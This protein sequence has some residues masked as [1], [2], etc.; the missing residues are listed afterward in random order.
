M[1]VWRHGIISDAVDSEAGVEVISSLMTLLVEL[2]NIMEEE[3]STKSNARLELE[4][5][6]ITSCKGKDV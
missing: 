1:P 2:G 6:R 5:H 3:V 4:A